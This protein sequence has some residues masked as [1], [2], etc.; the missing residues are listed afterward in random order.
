VLKTQSIDPDN[1]IKFVLSLDYI[2]FWQK[3]DLSKIHSISIQ[4]EVVWHIVDL[5]RA[6][7]APS[8]WDP[9]SASVGMTAAKDTMYSQSD[10]PPAD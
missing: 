6:W 3:N 10:V 2:R 8:F 4:Y 7:S 9:G 5:S 1:C